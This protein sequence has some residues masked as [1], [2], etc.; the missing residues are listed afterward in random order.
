MGAAHPPHANLSAQQ[1]ISGSP[2]TA[3]C[4]GTARPGLRRPQS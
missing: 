4:A 2:C 1:R 3:G